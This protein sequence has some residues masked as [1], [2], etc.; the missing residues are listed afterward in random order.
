MKENDSELN[1][2]VPVQAMPPCMTLLRENVRRGGRHGGERKRGSFRGR[3]DEVRSTKQDEAI[4]RLLLFRF[5]AHTESLS[6]C[7]F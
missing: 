6:P 3:R 5:P 1:K 4:N 2:S 7:V